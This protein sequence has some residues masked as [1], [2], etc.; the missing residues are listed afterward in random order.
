MA[1]AD[2]VALKQVITLLRGLLTTSRDELEA[3]VSDSSAADTAFTNAENAHNAAIVAQTNGLQSLNT[4]KVNAIS[5]ANDAYNQG[6]AA[7]QD[8]VNAAKLVVDSTNS[9][10]I[11]NNALLEADRD[12]LNS[13]ISTLTTVIQMMEGVLGINTVSPT[14]SPTVTAVTASYYTMIRGSCCCPVEDR[15]SSRDECYAALNSLELNVDTLWEG[16]ENIIPGQCSWR[17]HQ[18]Q[19]I[20][21]NQF[22]EAGIARGDMTPVCRTSV[23]T[24]WVYQGLN[25]CG[26]QIGASD[27]ASIG[28]DHTVESCGQSCFDD[29]E[30]AGLSRPSFWYRPSDGHCNIYQKETG[31]KLCANNGN[32]GMYLHN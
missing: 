32:G 17:G 4:T 26:D 25:T 16:N 27:Y 22:S 29:P 19:N 9:T 10:K 1:D 3:L 11:T 21:W 5:S 7:L 8:A 18:G 20:H 15:I 30:C 28:R 23:S 12:R 6:V 2:P 31:A 14:S 24:V 13:E